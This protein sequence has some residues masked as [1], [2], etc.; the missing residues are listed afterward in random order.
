[1][2]TT[3]QYYNETAAIAT[4]QDTTNN[5]VQEK[6]IFHV[7]F[8][9]TTITQTSTGNTLV[10]ELRNSEGRTIASVLGSQ[11]ETGKYG[12]Y[13]DKDALLNTQIQEIPTTVALGDSFNIK[14]AS[15]FTQQ[16]VN[17]KIIYDTQYLDKKMGITINVWDNTAQTLLNGQELMG[18]S[19]EINGTTYYPNVNGTARIKVA[20]NVANILSNITVKTEHNKTLTTG[21]YTI[22]VDT[23]ASAD[24]EYYEDDIRH[25][26]KKTVNIKNSE[27][28]LKL[29]ISDEDRIIE[30][31]KTSI[32]VNMEKSVANITT[33]TFTV[34]AYRRDYTEELSTTYNETIN[35][36]AQ[37]TTPTFIVTLPTDIKTGTYKIVV[38]LYD[39]ETYIGEAH[40]YFIV[41]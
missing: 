1:M 19:Y 37:A 4:Y 15:T 9:E 35:I 31:G 26:D 23:L 17:G 11:R 16:V 12:I 2:P 25:H 36:T 13:V 28:G 18:I 22:V 14:A 8:K 10:M 41:T 39:G 21:D 7:D 3:N 24:G 6:F 30:K 5:I 32:T 27:Y 20:D 33:P 29:T 34:K 40:D 38:E